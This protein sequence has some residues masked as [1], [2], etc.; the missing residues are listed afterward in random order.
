[1]ALSKFMIEIELIK[2][3]E[4][5]LADFHTKDGRPNE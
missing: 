2:F 1:M 3:D 5:C 4:N